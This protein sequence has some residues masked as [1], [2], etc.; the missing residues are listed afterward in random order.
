MATFR[1]GIENGEVKALTFN[2]ALRQM[3]EQYDVDNDWRWVL[4]QIHYR[5]R[6][7]E[8]VNDWWFLWQ[9]LKRAFR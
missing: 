8:T 6:V 7:P 5:R 3:C 4:M 9:A 1:D 2:P